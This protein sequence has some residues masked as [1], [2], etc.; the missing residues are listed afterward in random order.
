VTIWALVI[1]GLLA[2]LLL[3]AVRWFRDDR[4]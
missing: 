1:S 2:T 4:A 3:L